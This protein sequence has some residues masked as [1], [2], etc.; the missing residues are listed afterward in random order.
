MVAMD[1]LKKTISD[2]SSVASSKGGSV[3]RRLACDQEA[4]ISQ[5]NS[6][7]VPHDTIISG[8]FMKDRLP[9]I[10]RHGILST[11]AKRSKRPWPLL[12]SPPASSPGPF[13]Q[14]SHTLKSTETTMRRLQPSPVTEVSCC[15]GSSCSFLLPLC[16][17]SERL[18]TCFNLNPSGR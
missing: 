8:P 17:F 7:T 10:P 15:F 9:T 3:P 18:H 14:G 11:P 1:V 2:S 12:S 6:D 16:K 5:S 4:P 13:L